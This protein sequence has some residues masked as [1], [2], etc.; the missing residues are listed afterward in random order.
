MQG[1][2]GSAFLYGVTQLA[3]IEIQIYL[4]IIFG[5]APSFQAA[6]GAASE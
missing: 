4:G 5:V 2:Q 1:S 6:R 3:S